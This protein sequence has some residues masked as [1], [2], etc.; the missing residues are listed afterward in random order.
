MTSGGAEEKT[1]ATEGRVSIFDTTLRDGEQSPGCSMNLDEK[2]RMA[3]QLE[4]LHVDVIEAGFPVASPGDFDAVQA[5]AAATRESTIAALSRAVAPDIER[6]WEAIRHAR[7]PRIH[8]FIATS[9]I[10][11]AH[12]LR[13]S[14]AQ[15]LAD[16]AEAVSCARRLCPEVEFSCEDASRSDPGFLCEVVAAAVEA[17][18]SIINLPDTV[19]YAVPSEYG[20]MFRTVRER[21]KGVGR[22]ILSAHCHNDLGMAVANSL[23]ALE[24]GARQVE[25]TMNGIGERAGNAAL[26]EIVMA[27]ATRGERLRL[28]TGVMTE[29]I[30]RSS[31]LLV[32]LTGMQVQRNKAIV[33]ANAFAHEAGIHQDG[34]LKSAITYEIMTPQSVGIRHSTL[35]LGK[36]SGRHALKARYAELGYQLSG[37]E[38]DQAYRAFCAIADQKK[39]VFDEELVALLEERAHSREEDYHLEGLQVSTGMNMRPTATITLRRV[40]RR[41]VD[42]ATGDGPVDAAYKAIERITGASGRLLE[43]AVKSVSLGRDAVGEAFVS[44]EFDGVVFRGRAIST[45]VIEG[46]VRAYLEALNRALASQRAREGAASAAPAAQEVA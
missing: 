32:S 16:V 19:G 3:H 22:V 20:A 25:C 40:D 34:V 6:A 44:V 10:H 37:E 31:K 36:H 5:V 11:L 18:A 7:K 46:S 23:A 39:E 38:L 30:V 24:A 14:R 15:V 4:R 33:G 26:E 45:D 42:S 8:T 35:V 9:D 27:I 28:W 2:L 41:L 1:R 43:Y 12:K 29:E 13:R 17:G 21:V